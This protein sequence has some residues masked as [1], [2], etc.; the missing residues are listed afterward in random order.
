MLQEDVDIKTTSQTVI[1][2]QGAVVLANFATRVG[3]RVMFRISHKGKAVPFG[4]SVD[5]VQGDAQDPDNT[6]IVGGNGEVYLSGVPQEGKLAVQWGASSMERCQVSF[7]LP[8]QPR[9]GQANTG[10]PVTN[11][12]ALCL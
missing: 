11:Q 7:V 2:T 12:E 10:S 8:S 4:A 1:P 3:V 9:D 6:S 5:L